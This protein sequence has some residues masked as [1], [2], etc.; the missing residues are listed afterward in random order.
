MKTRAILI[1]TILSLTL[2]A[3]KCKENQ[4]GLSSCDGL[5]NI[6]FKESSIGVDKESTLKLISELAAAAKT[7]AI[8][9]KAVTAE[10][11]LNIKSEFGKKLKENVTG[12]Q[13]VSDDFWEQNITLTQLLC[14]TEKQ[15]KRKDLT[16]ME[17]SEYNKLLMQML[18]DR[19]EYLNQRS[20][21]KNP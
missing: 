2:M 15:S 18:A 1:V 7:D 9:S 17:R 20:L 16:Q 8:T 5:P 19:N 13:D 4:A 10:A 11:S 12:S 6:Q 21:K 3:N 14:F